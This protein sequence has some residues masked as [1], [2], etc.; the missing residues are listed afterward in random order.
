MHDS[1]I[2]VSNESNKIFLLF[3][4]FKNLLLLFSLFSLIEIKLIVETFLII[5]FLILSSFNNIPLNKINNEN[6]EDI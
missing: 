3:I 4:K 5:L 6:N 2:K 1:N